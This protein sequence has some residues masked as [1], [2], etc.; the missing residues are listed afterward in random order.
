MYG[1]K[2]LQMKTKVVFLQI[3]QLGLNSF[4]H[5]NIKKSGK[6]ASLSVYTGM[7]EWFTQRRKFV[8]KVVSKVIIAVLRKTTIPHVM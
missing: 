6:A 7:L 2:Y 3:S 1:E 5:A 8:V 4:F